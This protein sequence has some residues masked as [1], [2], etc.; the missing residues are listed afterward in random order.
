MLGCER[1]APIVSSWRVQLQQPAAAPLGRKGELQDNFKKL[2]RFR[3][4]VGRLLVILPTV[5]DGRGSAL[6]LEAVGR[7]SPLSGLDTLPSVDPGMTL[8]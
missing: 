5:E 2:L 4:L 7:S 1:Y 3:Q 6:S 8:A